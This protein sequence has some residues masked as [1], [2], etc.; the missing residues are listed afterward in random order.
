[1]RKSL[2]LLENNGVLPLDARAA[3]VFVAGKNADNIGHQCGGWT[4]NWQGGSGDITPGTTILDGIEDA[5]ADAGGIGDVQRGRLGLG[6]AR[7]R[8]RGDRRDAVRRVARR[9]RRPLA[10]DTTDLACL[11]RIGDIPT[12]VVLVSGRPLMITERMRDWDAVVAAWLPGTEGDGV[13][14]VLFGEH[15]FIGQAAHTAGPSASSRCRSTWR[16]RVRPAVPV[17]VRAG[18]SR[19]GPRP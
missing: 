11:D 14:D 10:L 15:D 16:R 19:R 7:R 6:R 8:D 5:V 18:L 9:R 1:V 2:V 4:I 13:A 12:V 17:R 3:G